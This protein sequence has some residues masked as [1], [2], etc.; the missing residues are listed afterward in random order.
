MDSEFIGAAALPQVGDGDA[1]SGDRTI[2]LQIEETVTVSCFERNL[3]YQVVV[4]LV[5]Y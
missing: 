4:E 5:R 3:F 1:H 2:F